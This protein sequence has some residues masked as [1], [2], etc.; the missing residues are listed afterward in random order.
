VCVSLSECSLPVDFGAAAEFCLWAFLLRS[1]RSGSR[2]F[3]PEAFS[4]LPVACAACL[5]P[6][7]DRA[8]VSSVLAHLPVPLVQ[9]C[10]RSEFCFSFRHHDILLS[11]GLAVRNLS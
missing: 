8:G 2:V 1:S 6:S 7:R 10:S 4:F 9:F 11:L 5:N 3:F